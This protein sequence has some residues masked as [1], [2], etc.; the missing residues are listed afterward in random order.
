MIA[1]GLTVILRVNGWRRG[2]GRGTVYSI[3]RCG[4]I[5]RSPDSKWLV[6]VS[7]R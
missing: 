2:N 5:I 1:M 4:N 6:R 7:S 3:G